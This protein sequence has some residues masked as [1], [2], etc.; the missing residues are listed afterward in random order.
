M[1]ARFE[2]SLYGALVTS[3]L[4]LVSV[5]LYFVEKFR[6]GIA[7][8]ALNVAILFVLKFVLLSR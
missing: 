8:A 7:A 4:T 6:L 2:P 5:S 1:A 3:I